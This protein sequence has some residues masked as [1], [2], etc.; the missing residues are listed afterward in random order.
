M[1]L[2]RGFLSMAIRHKNSQADRCLGGV[3]VRPFALADFN[4]AGLRN[5]LGFGR[6]FC[7]GK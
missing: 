1:R 4:L 7:A 6:Q 5:R 2:I 3:A